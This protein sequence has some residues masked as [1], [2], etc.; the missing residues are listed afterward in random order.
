MIDRIQVAADLQFFK[1]I[2]TGDAASL[3]LGF[4]Q[5]QQQQRRQNGN[6]GNH[7]QQI[8]ESE[9]QPVGL[10]SIGDPPVPSGDSPDGARA[11]FRS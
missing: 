2:Q 1:V 8:N 3:F 5:H 11:R 10:G 7:Q 9:T 4:A 6:D